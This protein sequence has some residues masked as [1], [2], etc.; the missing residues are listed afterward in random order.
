LREQEYPGQTRSWYLQ[1]CDFFLRNYL[2]NGRSVDSPRHRGRLLPWEL[3]HQD[4]P[5][6][7]DGFCEPVGLVS[8]REILA[9]LDRWLTPAERQILQLLAQGFA[10]REVASRLKLSHTSV[11]RHRRRIAEVAVRM[12]VEPVPPADRT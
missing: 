11:V 4:A 7:K 12:G 5:G 8:A 1:S 10:V 6:E 3:R 2:R 9:L